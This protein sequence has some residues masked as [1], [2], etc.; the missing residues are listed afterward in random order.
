MGGTNAVRRPLILSAAPY[1]TYMH[2]LTYS[3]HCCTSDKIIYILHSLKRT[4]CV[5]FGT[6]R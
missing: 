4:H 3:V 5:C 6:R 2:G 1:S